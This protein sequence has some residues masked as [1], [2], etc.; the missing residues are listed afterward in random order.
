MMPQ[1]LEHGL[2]LLVRQPQVG[3]ASNDQMTGVVPCADGLDRREEHRDESRHANDSPRTRETGF[4]STIFIPPYAGSSGRGVV[5]SGFSSDDGPRSIA[6]AHGGP[7][8]PEPQ[9]IGA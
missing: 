3:D 9:C 8:V 7:S 2:A 5:A 1:P 6:R 4:T